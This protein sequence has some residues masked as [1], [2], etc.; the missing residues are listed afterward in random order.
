MTETFSIKKFLSDS[1]IYTLSNIVN[2]AIPFLLLPFIVSTISVTQYGQYSLFIT[3]EMLLLP[4]IS[5]N[6]HGALEVHFFDKIELNLKTYISGLVALET[7]ALVVFFL[8]LLVLPGGISQIA[9]VDRGLLFFT[10]FSAFCSSIVQIVYSHLRVQKKSYYY[11]ILLS[12]QSFVLFGSLLISVSINPSINFLV[13]AR[14]FTSLVFLFFSIYY[15]I[16]NDFITLKIDFS[17]IK[18]ALKFSLPSIPHTLSAFIFVASDRFQI[19]HFLGSKQV[20]LFSAVIQISSVISVLGASF[21][22]A[23]SPW[24]FEQ[25]RKEDLSVNRRVVKLSYLLMIACIIAS[26]IF[27]IAIPYVGRWFLPTTYHSSFYLIKYFAFGYTFQC[28]Y[29]IVVPYLYISQKTSRLS[30]N[31]FI[32]AVI[33]VVVNFIFLSKYGLVVAGIANAIS[34]MVLFL[35]TFIMSSK[36]YKM[37]WRIWEKV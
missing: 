7:T 1:A 17:S 14:A 8:I 25:L 34:W 11:G 10:I 5:M 2:K 3:L 30:L 26:I 18:K 27:V 29:F 22:I 19:E 15:F 9:G 33:S 20:G 16:K 32:A 13:Y 23:W 4:F 21:G 35:I 12:L 28:L 6:L 36:M 31:S 37:P 24:L